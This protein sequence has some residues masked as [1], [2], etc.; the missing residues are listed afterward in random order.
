MRKISSKNLENCKKVREKI[1]KL[2]SIE[3]LSKECDILNLRIKYT[4]SYSGGSIIKKGKELIYNE[5]DIHLEPIILGDGIAYLPILYLYVICDSKKEDKF[6]PKKAYAMLQLKQTNLVNYV[7][8]RE[9]YRLSNSL[10]ET[11]NSLPRTPRVNDYGEWYETPWTLKK[12]LSNI[13]S[14]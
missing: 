14:K 12:F 10:L 1:K 5:E 11:I 9:K 3:E 2:L 6:T 7:A 13:S 8:N 4:K